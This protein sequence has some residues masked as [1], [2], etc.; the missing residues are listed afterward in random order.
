[1]VGPTSNVSFNDTP[2]DDFTDASNTARIFVVLLDS[3]RTACTGRNIEHV[4]WRFVHVSSGN[5]LGV[6][7]LKV[8]LHHCAELRE[9]AFATKQVFKGEK[10]SNRLGSRFTQWFCVRLSRQGH[11]KS[12]TVS[13]QMVRFKVLDNRSLFR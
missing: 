2:V 4:L 7:Q 10:P 9:L 8:F 11:N 1:M 12:A 3:L 6:S 13:T 5:N